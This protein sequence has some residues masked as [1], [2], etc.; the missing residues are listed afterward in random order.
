MKHRAASWVLAGIGAVVAISVM[1]LFFDPGINFSGTLAVAPF[2]PAVAASPLATAGVGL[3]AIVVG[4]ALFIVDEPPLSVMIAQSA[5]VILAA[6]MA[7]LAARARQRRERA[8]RDLSRVANVAQRAILAPIAPTV[9]PVAISA[10]YLS[11]S[12]DAL[13]GGDLYAVTKTDRGVRLILGDVRGKGL[14]AV[15]LAALVVAAFREATRSPTLADVIAVIEDQLRP[16]LGPEDFVTAIIAEV[17][18]DGTC[19][20]LSC[21]H[22]PPALWRDGVFH[23]LDEI[24]PTTPFGLDADP[25]PHT[26]RLRNGDRLLFYTDGL[27]EARAPNGGFI[28]LNSLLAG[29]GRDALDV[30]LDRLVLRLRSRAGEITDDLALLLVQFCTTEA[31]LAPSGAT[32]VPTPRALQSDAP[33]HR[34]LQMAHTGLSCEVD[35]EQWA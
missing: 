1:D 27:V 29:L 5:A 17:G 28:E 30:V 33:P 7:P 20:L 31:K 13:I 6:V 21:G 25:K 22:H 16:E 34:P 11:A 2:I 32:R 3:L 35:E 12:R 23:V 9:G 26:L 15:A 4:L 10:A 18:T 14:D 19:T 24:E 8:L